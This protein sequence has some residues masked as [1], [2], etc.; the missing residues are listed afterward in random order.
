[1]SI[2]INDQPIGTLQ[3]GL[4]GSIVPKTVR[5][6]EALCT[7]ENGYGYKDSIFH[8]VIAG[9]MAQGGNFNG[10]GGKSIYGRTFPDEN[11]DVKHFPRCLAMA[12]AGK[13]TNGSQFYITT[14]KTSHLDGKHVVF[15]MLVD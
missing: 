15:G 2:S 11:F 10:K 7:G 13:D 3:L 14:V 6:F 1:M 4:F 12:N 5:N 8:R 9:F